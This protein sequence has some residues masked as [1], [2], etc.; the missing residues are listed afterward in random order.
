MSE[1]TWVKFL[2]TQY[3]SV[4]CKHGWQ[5]VAKVQ[6]ESFFQ[7]GFKLCSLWTFE[8]QALV[9]YLAFELNQYRDILHINSTT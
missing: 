9:S 2:I 7:H 6:N 3:L 1:M 5:C 4:M 8:F